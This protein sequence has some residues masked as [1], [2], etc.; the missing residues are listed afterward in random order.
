LED[1]VISIA[2]KN[3]SLNLEMLG[4][5]LRVSRSGASFLVTKLKR[6]GKM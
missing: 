4:E 1:E 6:E 5:K 2:Q 3:A